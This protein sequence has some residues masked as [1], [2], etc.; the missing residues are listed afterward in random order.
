MKKVL[1]FVTIIALLNSEKGFGMEA[2]A[3]ELI[4]EQFEENETQ[5]LKALAES[6]NSDETNTK[7]PMQFTQQEIQRLK[8]FAQFFDQETL[9]VMKK[10]VPMM[11]MQDQMIQYLGINPM[12]MMEAMM[13]RMET[14]QQEI[15]RNQQTSPQSHQTSFIQTSKKYDNEYLKYSSVWLC[16]AGGTFGLGLLSYL[17]LSP[18]RTVRPWVIGF[19]AIGSGV[20]LYKSIKNIIFHGS[21]MLQQ[22]LKSMMTK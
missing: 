16:A 11:K 8:A 12:H 2:L 5:R 6:L 20:C 13:P 22:K 17:K 18:D 9:E 14:E 4:E 15:L 10:Q 7:T 3:D 1:F 19:G 21:I